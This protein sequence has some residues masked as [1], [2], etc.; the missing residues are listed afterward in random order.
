[1][2]WDDAFYIILYNLCILNW[3]NAKKEILEEFIL[4]GFITFV[5][6]SI[7]KVYNNRKVKYL[8]IYFVCARTAL[9]YC[10]CVHTT[11]ITHTP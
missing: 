10:K 3:G 1:M 11:C 7:W 4:N 8:A 9:L 5:R 2:E 6:I